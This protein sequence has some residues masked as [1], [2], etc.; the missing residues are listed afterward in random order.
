MWEAFSKEYDYIQPQR[1]DIRQGVVVSIE[2]NQIV[3]DIGAK[4]EGI[5]TSYDLEKLGE[6]AVSQISV[7]DEVLAYV[8]KPETR[9]GEVLLSLNMAR[10]IKDW[11]RAESMFETQELF[12]AEVT[13]HNK[14]GLLVPFGRVRGFVPA[15]QIVDLEGCTDSEVRMNQLAQMEG[16][17]LRLQVIEVDRRRR[18]L[19]LSERAAER[20]WRAKQKELLLR[21]LREG[22]V[23]RGRVSNLVNFGAF[24]DL[25]GTDGLIHISEL[26]WQRVRHPRELLQVGD[27]VDVYVLRVDRERGRIGLSLKQ[28]YPD[29]WSTVEER[30]SVGQVVEGV[31]TNVV[32][33]GAFA[34][35]EPGIEGLIHSS[36]LLED[37]ELDP[38]DVVEEGEELAL[39]IISLDAR[40]RRMGLSLTQAPKPVEA[41]AEEEE[42]AEQL[43]VP[44][45]R[46]E[47]S[48]EVAIEVEAVEPVV[49][50]LAE[51]PPAEPMLEV[52][53]EP[54]PLEE[55]AEELQ[56]EVPPPP[57]ETPV[58]EGEAA[59]VA[60]SE[61]VEPS[62]EVVAEADEPLVA[63]VEPVEAPADLEAEAATAVA[64]EEETSESVVVAASSDN[65][66]TE[67]DFEEE[68]A[69]QSAAET[70]G[71]PPEEDSTGEDDDHWAT[72]E[73][74]A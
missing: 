58:E 36:E 17:T 7:G 31:V 60:L 29:P 44:E 48:A 33:F 61:G 69:P 35:I 53:G 5:V 51:E 24:V 23:R 63:E 70:E 20:Q 16:R 8:L 15:S 71:E 37:P 28:L 25:G 6:E 13:G 54:P 46:E 11:E 19:I 1:G 55:V 9:D 42:E 68:E 73:E 40:R 12:E 32:N 27:E 74:T 22:E 18:R 67:T 3:V 66:S 47:P 72:V 64:E 14:G 59:P 50:E 21:E 4:K 65:S 57:P 41:E 45:E 26:S 34:R 2:E 30:Y 38:R 49:Q 43:A 56:A 39:R 52:E 10:T 62:E